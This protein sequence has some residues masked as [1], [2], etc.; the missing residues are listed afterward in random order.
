MKNT[1]ISAALTSTAL[2]AAI[3][4][5]AAPIAAADV[6]VT[7][8]GDEAE[9]V[10]GAVVQGWTVTAL[11]PSSDVIPHPVRGV[12]WE[13][14]ATDNA[15]AGPVTPIV[16][17]F[18]A[19]AR[20]GETYRVLFG[21]ATPQGVNPAT[22]AQGQQTTGKLYFDITGAEPDSVVYNAGGTDLLLWVTPPPAPSGGANARPTWTPGGATSGAGA[23]A[24]ST[25][26]DG[27][28]PAGEVPALPAS[29]GTLPGDAE[30]PTG[31]S[32]TPLPA[33]SQGTPIGTPAPA[34][35][36][37]SSAVPP[38]GSQGTPVGTPAPGAT[39]A[40]VPHGGGSQGTPVAPGMSPASAAPAAVTPPPAGQPAPAAPAGSQG[41][42]ASAA[43][44][45][46]AAPATTPVLPPPA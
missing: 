32:G 41:T 45:A 9:L 8:L 37:D 7:T 38:A 13:A 20:N 39:A 14:T 34:P 33:G 42:P 3:G 1:T 19:R 31:S 26:T 28:A 24:N 46:P 23:A 10:N 18:N 15:I 6:T 40:G 30:V 11:K 4:L 29:T 17:N 27:V 22:I 43:P 21:A 2:A 12:L 16:S 5:A 36:T 25:P 35:G 44:T